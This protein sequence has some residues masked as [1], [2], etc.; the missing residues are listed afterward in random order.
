MVEVQ[1]RTRQDRDAHAR[2]SEVQEAGNAACASAACECIEERL[3]EAQV[4]TEDD[5]LRDAEECRYDRG[6]VESALL[7]ILRARCDSG[8][9]TALCDDGARDDGVER[10]DARRGEQL[11]L[12]G[13]EDVVDTEDD[14]DL[15]QA[16]DDEAADAVRQGEE[17]LDGAEDGE[18][19]PV[20][21]RA[22]DQE[23]EDHGDEERQER[24]DDEVN[25]VRDEGLEPFLELRS[26]DAEDEGRQDGT[27]VA[28]DRHA[29]A[30]DV[31][32]DRL[33]FTGG[34]RVGIRQLRCDEH[35]AEDDADDRRAAEALR[36]GP[37]D[38]GRQEGEG[39]IR[40]DLAHAQDVVAELDAEAQAGAAQAHEET[41]C[42]E[43]R[44]DRHED[45]AERAGDLL[46]HR[47]L[48]VCLSLVV[49]GTGEARAGDE[50]VVHLVDEACA[51]DNL[52]LGR[53]KELALDAVD[54]LDG[55]RVELR[56]VVDDQAQARRAVLGTADVVV[57]ADVLPDE[58][59]DALFLRQVAVVLLRLCRGS[60]CIRLRGG[61][62]CRL[63]R[64]RRDL[65]V[66]ERHRDLVVVEGVRHEDRRRRVVTG[67][68]D[69]LRVELQE[70]LALLD[71]IALRN[72][73][74][75]VLAA[76]VDR[77]DAD[78]DQD[79]CAVLSMDA[80]G[81]LRAEEHRDCAIDRRV[82]LAVRVL[83]GSALAHRAA[84]EGRILDIFQFDELS[85]E[86]TVQANLFHKE[87]LLF[88]IPLVLL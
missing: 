59:R 84:R 26:E 78:V 48:C 8:S 42:D 2:A 81:V 33:C 83:D 54:V 64:D 39:R 69:A 46:G 28:D 15:M 34:N 43:D 31:H 7:L 87:F 72:L 51:E 73:G 12:K 60:G 86:R 29:K 25:D 66:A 14:D 37:A 36:R 40:E 10:I 76:E 71:R 88:F 58:L 79:V 68:L 35:E 77:V 13:I 38:E 61:F 65:L 22:D 56:L 85:I 6:D 3:H 20:H 9:G 55:L 41:G 21:D 45:V 44:D 32:H 74:V 57:A 70:Q 19:N 80:D 67:R 63:C 52:V 24:R 53:R 17:R 16:A 5:R 30:E 62:F 50:G 27:L 4:D 82:D 11:D 75:E 1:Q 49:A 23:A 18:L 47:H